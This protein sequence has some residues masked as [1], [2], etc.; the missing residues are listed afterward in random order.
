MVA[1]GRFARARTALIRRDCAPS[2][3]ALEA[4]ANSFTEVIEQTSGIAASRI[5]QEITA[6]ALSAREA[7]ALA[8]PAG[9]PALRMLRRYFD[10]RDTPYFVAESVHPAERF[11]YTMS[12]NRCPSQE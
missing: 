3:E 6:C 8:A 7:G 5:E 1:C 12:F 10:Q 11:I 2:R 4:R 9:A